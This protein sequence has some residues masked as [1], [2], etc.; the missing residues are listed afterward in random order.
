MSETATFYIKDTP[1]VVDE[2][3]Y[4]LAKIQWRLHKNHGNTYAEKRLKGAVFVSLHRVIM[5]RVV[6]RKLQPG[7]RVD[8]IDGLGTNNSRSNLRVATNAQNIANSKVSKNNK[9]NTK[10]VVLRRGKYGAVIM[11]NRKQ[12][13]LGVFNTKEE[14]HEAY[15]SAARRYFGEFARG[16]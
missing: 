13:W 7:E 14:A 1:I 11:V 12:K 10:G 4:D 8:H 2:E 5:E 15:M 6:G 16:E 3:D 9:L